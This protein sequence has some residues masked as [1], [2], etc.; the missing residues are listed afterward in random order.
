ME[1][2]VTFSRSLLGWEERVECIIELS[3]LGIVAS[4]EIE[5]TEQV[6]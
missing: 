4:L 6:I 3:A 5:E 2:F 1:F